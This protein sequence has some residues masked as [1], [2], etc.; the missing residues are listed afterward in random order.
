MADEIYREVV[1]HPDG[2]SKTDIF[3]L[4][5]GN[6]PATQL[7][8]ALAHLQASGLVYC[9]RQKTGG[10]PREVWRAHQ[11]SGGTQ[12]NSAVS[13]LEKETQEKIGLRFAGGPSQDPEAIE[14]RLAIQEEACV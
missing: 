8:R 7:D 1:T 12:A 9:D 4:F 10:R 3:A 5:K 14:E 2:I 11:T 6:R 13:A